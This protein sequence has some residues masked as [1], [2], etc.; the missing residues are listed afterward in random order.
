MPQD[1]EAELLSRIAQAEAEVEALKASMA[2]EQLKLQI[3]QQA[4][5][6]QRGATPALHT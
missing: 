5:T 1:A 2:S 6:K 3:R 4:T